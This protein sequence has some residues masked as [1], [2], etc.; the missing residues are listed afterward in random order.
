MINPSIVKLVTGRTI[1][2]AK[3]IFE[4]YNCV[5]RIVSRKPGISSR[6]IV[7]QLSDHND[8]R[9]SLHLEAGRIVKVTPG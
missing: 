5:Y 8:D 9:Y 7:T 2:E 4:T 6:K 3:S 1:E